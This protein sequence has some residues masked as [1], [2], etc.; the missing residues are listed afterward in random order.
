[1]N[2]RQAIRFME[3]GNCVISDFDVIFCIN[4]IGE[5]C[6]WDECEETWF[7]SSLSYNELNNYNFKCIEC[8]EKD[9]SPILNRDEIYFNFD[10]LT[11]EISTETFVSY[12]GF[13]DEKR[14]IP[15]EFFKAIKTLVQLKSHPLARKAEEGVEQ[16]LIAHAYKGLDILRTQESFSNKFKMQYVSPPFNTRDDCLK[17][18]SDIGEDIIM[19]MFKTLQG[20]K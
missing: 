2:F 5:I 3:R 20:V 6:G 19:N 10:I 9:R 13:I 1:M 12:I 8:P 15:H 18:M 14:G 11:E 7:K 16:F 17:A 4:S